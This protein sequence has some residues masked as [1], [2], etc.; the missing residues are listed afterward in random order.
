MSFEVKPSYGMSDLIGLVERL[1]DPESG[2]PWDAEQDHASIR[3]DLLE[4]AYET[5]DAIDRADDTD[6]LEELGDLLFQVVFHAELARE[7]GKFDLDDIA[8]GII[9][10]MVL[11]HPHVFGDTEAKTSEKVLE[12][13]DAIKRVEKRQAGLYDELLAVP[14]AF[15]ALMRGQKLI[16]RATR[17][18]ALPADASLAADNLRTH[19]EDYLQAP[20]SGQALGTL[21]LDLCRM[22]HLAGVSAEESL[23]RA[24]E[25]WINDYA[26][27]EEA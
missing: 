15:P 3:N 8:D 20:A 1:R 2:C 4:E 16:K 10:K 23:D 24:A 6:L 19:M 12:N 25:A 27:K 7:E 14:R 9:R 21:L 26:P 18:G 11:R 22:A 5:A 13:W 17:A